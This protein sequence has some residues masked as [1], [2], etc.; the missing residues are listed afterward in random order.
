LLRAARFAH[1]SPPRRYDFSG[2]GCTSPDEALS[3]LQT[4]EGIW[5]L[6]PKAEDGPEQ[7]QFLEEIEAGLSTEYDFSPYLSWPFGTVDVPQS[8]AT[9]A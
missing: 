9:A 7:L 8:D 6:T 5:T 1:C 3:D 2:P 4:T